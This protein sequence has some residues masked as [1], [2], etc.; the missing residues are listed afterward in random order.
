M[1]VCNISSCSTYSSAVAACIGLDNAAR[2]TWFMKLGLLHISFP[3]FESC[4]A[5][6][7]VYTC[8]CLIVPLEICTFYFRVWFFL[9][10][11]SKN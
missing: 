8:M 3:Q 6:L 7:P 10:P 1:Q 9:G 2:K 5:Y 11:A 4:L